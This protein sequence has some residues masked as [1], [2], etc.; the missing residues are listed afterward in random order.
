MK[1]IPTRPESAAIIDKILL[2]EPTARMYDNSV[3]TTASAEL[4]P[5]ALVD[6][7][8]LGSDVEGDECSSSDLATPKRQKSLCLPFILCLFVSGLVFDCSICSVGG[9]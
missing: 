4:T 2:L 3:F 8:A 5:E 7:D 6:V 9:D 1:N